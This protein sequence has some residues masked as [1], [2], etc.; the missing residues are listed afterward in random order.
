M[1][2]RLALLKKQVLAEIAAAKTPAE[3]ERL[4]V[5]YMGRKAGELTL[6]LRSLK[7]LSE[8]ERRS[9]GQAANA[10]KDELI[11]VLQ[12]R[13]TQLE[14]GSANEAIDLT[15]PGRKRFVGYRHPITLVTD[16][17]VEIFA[18]MGFEEILGPEIETDWYN[19][20]ALNI[21]K[22]H[23]ARGEMFGNFYLPGGL[24]LRSHTSPVQIRVMENMPPPVRV[25]APG[26]VYRRDAFDS[27]HSPVFYQVEGLYVDEG[28]SF[29]DLKGT[30]E[31]FS[32]E[33]FGSDIGVRFSP[34]YF[35]FT[36]PSAELSISC[37][38]CGGAGCKVC[39][40]TGWVEILGCGMVHPQVLRN[41]GYDPDKVTGF[42]FGMGVERIAMIHY[43]IDDIRHFYSNDLRF[44]RQFRET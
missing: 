41:V 38:I 19:F 43:R 40:H 16:R 37:V 32:Q 5:R 7:G 11:E 12:K 33:M 18:G 22:G 25:I 29:A 15:L 35:P 21:P 42:A 27:S 8:E 13:R 36:E 28:V 31:V 44:L 23:P 3:L 6:V 34:S 2:E 39:A 4:R 14:T 17:I 24:L 9:V 1:Q 26:R 20:E 30:L 10:L